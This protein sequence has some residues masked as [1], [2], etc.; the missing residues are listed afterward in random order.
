MECVALWLNGGDEIQP[1]GADWAALLMG[2]VKLTNTHTCSCETLSL[3][4]PQRRVDL[5]PESSLYFCLLSI[6]RENR[7]GIITFSEELSG[8]SAVLL[9]LISSKTQ[10]NN[11]CSVV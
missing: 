6:L 8:F 7:P 1:S 9:I 3:L 10:R 4:T 2:G 5:L 11:G